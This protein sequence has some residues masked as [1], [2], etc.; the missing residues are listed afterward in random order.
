MNKKFDYTQVYFE[1][2]KRMKCMEIPE[3]IYFII[4][5]AYNKHGYSFIDNCLR[6]EH[7]GIRLGE[8]LGYNGPEWLIEILEIH[9]YSY[10]SEG[11]KR[12]GKD[13]KYE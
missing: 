9:R 5:R 6:T 11:V 10:Q 7:P 3:Y 13:Y 2:E 1:E 8:S 12:L 4:Y